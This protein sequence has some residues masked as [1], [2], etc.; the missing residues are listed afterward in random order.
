MSG[1]TENTPWYV[2]L[3]LAIGG[4]VAGLLAALAIA[5]IATLAVSADGRLSE[6]GAATTALLLGAAF[7][8]L[9]VLCRGRG[10]FSRHFSNASAAAGLTA[11][12]GGAW[13]L[14]ARALA[15]SSQFEG[16]TAGFAGMI[17]AG[18]LAVASWGVDRR[19]RDA[20]FAFLAALAVFG[21]FSV[22][23]LVFEDQRG[24]GARFVLLTTACLALVGAYAFFH[25][26]GAAS[27][28]AAA[29]A[30]LV[31]SLIAFFVLPDGG[32]LVGYASDGAVLHGAADLIVFCAIAYGLFQLRSRAPM[33]AL[34]AVG[35]LSLFIA[36]LLPNY[37]VGALVVL[38]TGMAAFH[39]ALAGVGAF[40]LAVALGRYYYDLDLT[41]LTKSI[42]LILIGV[43]T[44]CTAFLVRWRFTEKRANRP[45]RA[46]AKTPR[47][48]FVEVVAV[49]VALGAGLYLTNASVHR[50]ET[51][52][53]DAREIY[54][55]L[56]P[57]DPRS[58]MQGDYMIL[59]FR[60]DIYP[61]TQTISSLPRDGEV[62]LLLDE[63]NV[64][65]FSR[66]P[67]KGARLTADEIR[68]DYVKTANKS[69]RYCP[70]SFF[71]QEGD[72]GAYQAARFAIV[73]VSD[74][75]ATLL[76]GLADENRKAISPS[77]AVGP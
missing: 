62:F 65:R 48:A 73:K 57:V 55:P 22:S 8:A 21:V 38:I 76:A 29:S 71:F 59:R 32:V 64:A 66:I 50:L 47:R 10:D 42:I 14:I 3:F 5:F 53:R 70:Q 19:F 58:I 36:A 16:V 33:R 43:L 61:D 51:G 20:I 74:S 63:N 9:G 24:E 68:I 28:R 44:L 37:A 45:T 56:G 13:Y 75:G 4:W 41:L 7:V 1:K 39:P 52:F 30:F 25:S 77:E 12:T 60:N 35:A 34:F 72:A 49:A 26:A 67:E 54:L 46:C 40:A 31:G 69:M 18:L 27:L 11:A 6:V 15:P 17:V 2:E 23:V